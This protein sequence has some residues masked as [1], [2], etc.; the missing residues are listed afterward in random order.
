[1]SNIQEIDAYIDSLVIPEFKENMMFVF[2]DKG[3]NEISYVFQNP[4]EIIRLLW[5]ESSSYFDDAYSDSLYYLYGKS[6]ELNYYL[7]HRYL[8]RLFENLEDVENGI[9]LIKIPLILDFYPLVE[10]GFVPQEV[11]TYQYNIHFYHLH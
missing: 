4:F 10:T 11:V 1:M 3:A 6:Y 8:K 2:I 9:L 5:N 7:A